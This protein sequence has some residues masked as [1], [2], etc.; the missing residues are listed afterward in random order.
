MASAQRLFQ[1]IDLKPEPADAPGALAPERC[2]GRV[3][4]DRVDFSYRKDVPLIQN[5]CLKVEPS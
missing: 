5:L 4:L 1:T 2:S 3:E